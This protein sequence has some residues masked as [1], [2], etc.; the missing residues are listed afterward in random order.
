[1]DVIISNKLSNLLK[2][3]PFLSN[4]YK[5]IKERIPG[6]WLENKIKFVGNQNILL[7]VW[8]NTMKYKSSVQWQRKYCR[9]M[10]LSGIITPN[11]KK[12]A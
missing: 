7:D 6:R 9:Q 5:L 8:W 10:L 1:M 12:K 2:M 11:K 3:S 4:A